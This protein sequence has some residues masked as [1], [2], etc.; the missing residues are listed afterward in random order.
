MHD[1]AQRSRKAQK[2]DSMGYGYGLGGLVITILVILLIL[3][4]VGVL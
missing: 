2:G 1:G 3:Y 4:L